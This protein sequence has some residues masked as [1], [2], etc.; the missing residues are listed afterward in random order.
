[1]HI[2]DPLLSIRSE[3]V[4]DTDFIA[5]LYRSTREDLSRLGLPE[6][7]LDN[8]I[9]MQLHAQQSG[10]RKQYPDADY[11]IVEKT[12]E[13]I[14][15]LITHRSDDDIRLVYIA[16]MPQER[17][18]GHGRRLIQALQTEASAAK[19]PLKL[20]VSTQNV[21]AQH[22]YA[23]SGFRVVNNDSVNLEM[24]WGVA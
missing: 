24:S 20:S 23:S 11:A 8:M 14:G 10:Y 7:M 4:Q 18:Q 6:A 22:L 15:Y 16:L 2:D 1:M 3:T 21:L 17:N 5:Q 12:G 13:S 9:A 19:K